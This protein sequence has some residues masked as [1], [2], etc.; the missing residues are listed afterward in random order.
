MRS[1]L[2]VCLLTASWCPSHPATHLVLCPISVETSSREA[3]C[4]PPCC[5]LRL[6]DDHRCIGEYNFRWFGGV[7]LCGG[8]SL[9]ISAVGTL[10]R[11]LD[12]GG[13]T[14]KGNPW[15]MWDVYTASFWILFGGYSEWRVACS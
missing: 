7:A 15:G 2:R 9:L 5:M 6:L 8:T 14:G 10:V 1:L 4:L 11:I 12:E 13:F 3:S